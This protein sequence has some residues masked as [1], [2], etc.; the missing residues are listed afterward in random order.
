MLSCRPVLI[1]P[2]GKLTL[3]FATPHPAELAVEAPDGTYFAL[4][5]RTGSPDQRPLVDKPS[6]KRMTDLQLDVSGAQGSPWAFGRNTNATIFTLPGKYKFVLA[7]ILE[8][9]APEEVYRC[10]VTLRNRK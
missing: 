6:F 1:A 5:P 9:D 7:D 2:G 10:V 8:T 3:H 4:E